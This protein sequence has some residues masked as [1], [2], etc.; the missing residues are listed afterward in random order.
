LDDD[1]HQDRD[2]STLGYCSYHACYVRCPISFSFS[3]DERDD[4]VDDA[5]AY[6]LGE[7]VLFQKTQGLNSCFPS[8]SDDGISEFPPSFALWV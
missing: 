7:A 8:E 6:D 1:F 4:D 3:N 5:H 2:L